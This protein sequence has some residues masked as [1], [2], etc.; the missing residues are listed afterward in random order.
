M[1]SNQFFYFLPANA[2]YDLNE[3]HQN[4]WIE[5]LRNHVVVLV[6]EK[7]IIYGEHDDSVDFLVAGKRLECLKRAD[8]DEKRSQLSVSSNNTNE[9]LAE[10]LGEFDLV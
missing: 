5:Q 1:E 3:E 4:Y 6:H 9:D 7:M 8:F 10:S 2:F